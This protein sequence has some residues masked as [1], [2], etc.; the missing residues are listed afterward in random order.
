MAANCG[1]FGVV[2]PGEQRTNIMVDVDSAGNF[3]YQNLH[4][5][6]GGDYAQD[7]QVFK[8]VDGGVN[9][10]DP[11]YAHGEGADKGRIA[12]DPQR[13]GQRWTYLCALAGR[14]G[15][16]AFYALYGRRRELRGS[17]QYSGRPSFGTIAVGPEGQVY[18]GGRSEI[19]S[20]SGAKLVFKR[21]SV[22]DLAQR[23]RSTGNA[24]LYD[25]ANQPG[26][27]ARDV[28]ISK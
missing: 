9:W 21:L 25:P 1:I 19:G 6:P 2:T 15:R 24:K 7:V 8:S 10:L 18:I 20:L 17:G 28:S 16:Q 4:Y 3:Y 27:F 5:G 14:L 26:R 12:V 23:A 11:V 22:F 13:H